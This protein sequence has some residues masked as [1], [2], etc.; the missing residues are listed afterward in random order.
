MVSPFP[1][2]PYGAKPPGG[3]APRP[4]GRG[5]GPRGLGE[6]EHIPGGGAPGVPTG[7]VASNLIIYLDPCHPGARG[8]SRPLSQ[9]H[10]AGALQR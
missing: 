2:N 3:A 7:R 9:K 10:G 1:P 8:L 6:G 5:A 4:G